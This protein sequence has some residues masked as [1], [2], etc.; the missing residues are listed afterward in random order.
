MRDSF[1]YYQGMNADV[2]GISVDSP[3]TLAKFKEEQGLP[4]PFI[5]GFQQR[6][7]LQAFGASIRRF[8]LSI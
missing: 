8:C 4:V 5:V 1:G 7:H 6:E 3:F 2:V